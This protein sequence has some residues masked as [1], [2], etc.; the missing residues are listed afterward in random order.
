M[1]KP[2]SKADI[3]A[4]LEQETERFLSGG[5]NV[6][7][8]PQGI[9]GK[10]PT[11]APLFLNRRLFIEPSAPRTLVPEVVAAIEARRKEKLKRSPA[12]KRSRLPRP[13][14]KVI[15][16]DFGEPLRKVWVED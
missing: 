6:E 10:D 5:G 2:A 8:I 9:S 4:Q 7:N 15:Y 1:K 13:R 16:D 14:R 3:R 11:D 12:P